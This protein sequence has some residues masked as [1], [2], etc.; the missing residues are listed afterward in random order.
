MPAAIP[1]LVSAAATGA[2]VGV[3]GTFA[4]T[5]GASLV[6]G[7][8]QQDRAESK[9][10]RAAQEAEEAARNAY[11]AS[12]Q[13]RLITVRSGVSTRKYVI[14]T[15]RTGGTLMYAN[16]TGE[17]QIAFDSIV[18]LASN[19]TELVGYYL[20]DEYVAAADFPGPKYGYSAG[21]HTA[22][23]FQQ[24]PFILS[25]TL[26]RDPIPGTVSAAAFGGEHGIVLTDFTV[27]GR[28]VTFSSGAY[29]D[30]E[31]G[32]SYKP[33]QKLYAIF[34]NGDPDQIASDWGSPYTSAEWTAEH[35][36]RGVTYL[37]TLMLWDEN[38]YA[39]GAPQ[40]GAVLSGGRVGEYRFIDPRT[41]GDTVFTRNPALVAY[42]WM[43]LP[44]GLG[45]MGIPDSWIDVQSIIN[46]ANICD[47]LMQVRTHNGQAYEWVK[48]Y[49]CNTVLDTANSPESNMQTILDAMAG[50]KVF[51]GGRYKIV[52]GA[53]RPATMVITDN[54]VIGDKPLGVVTAATTGAPPNIATGRFA[55]DQQNWIEAS[56]TPVRNQTYIDRD[57]FESPIDLNLVATTDSRR[58]RYLLGI[59]LETGRPAFTCTVSV[60]G[61]GEDV[62]LLDTVQLSINNRDEYRGR[63]FEVL[64]RT[65]NW[66]GTFQLTLS[67][68]RPQT[69]ELD[70]DTLTPVNPVVLPDL[71]Y[72]WNVAPL[73]G[74][75]VDFS[76][77]QLMPDGTGVSHITLSW[78]THSQA[79]VLQGGWVE[80]RYRQVGTANWSGIPEVEAASNGT[81]FSASLIDTA[82]YE[83]QGRVRNSL[84]AYSR[85]VSAY[86]VVDGVAVVTP[87]LR[88][89]ASSL[90]FSVSADGAIAPATITLTPI[91]GGP[92]TGPV[93][94]TLVSGNIQ[95]LT[96]AGDARIVAASDMIT[97]VATIEARATYGTT[98]LTDLVTLIKVYDGHPGDPGAPGGTG[99]AGA[100][101]LSVF[102]TNDPI[103]LPADYN[104]SVTSYTGANTT[105]VVFSGTVDDSS[106]WVYSRVLGPGVTTATLA[107]NVLTIG[108]VATSAPPK[109]YVEMVASHPT[110]PA[111]TRRV[112]IAKLKSGEPG[113]Q[114]NPGAAG[115]RGSV[116][117]ATPRSGTGWS[118]SIATNAIANAGA[119][120]PRHLDRVTIYSIDAN[121]S[122]MRSY[123]NGSWQPIA[124][125]IN[126]N[127]VVLGTLGAEHLAAKSITTDKLA[128]QASYGTIL[129][130]DPGIE[131]PSVWSVTPGIVE[132]ANLGQFGFF[133]RFFWQ[134]W[135]QSS[136]VGPVSPVQRNKKYRVSAR[137][138]RNA[139]SNATVYLFVH[140]RD[141]NGVLISNPAWPN[142][143]GTYHY[144]G[145]IN[146]SPSVDAWSEYTVVFGPGTG[147]E[148]PN[149]ATQMG[150][151]ALL[152]YNNAG[153]SAVHAMVIREMVEGELVV[154]GS[155]KARNV[156]LT[157]GAIKSSTYSGFA[158][159]PFGQRGF[160]LGPGG[161]LLGNAN[162]GTPGFFE[163]DEAGNV[164]APGM[165]II[166]GQMTINGI[167]VLGTFQV[168][169]RSIT[170]VS[171][172]RHAWSLSDM[173]TEP[174][175]YGAG[176]SGDS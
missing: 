131:D 7:A 150:V 92:L 167:N 22:Q 64:G 104:G 110:L 9:A 121:W 62:S 90:L 71:S 113:P 99:E 39:Q 50:R 149:N 152:S 145:L 100:D 30:I 137:A 66:D 3:L 173:P 127:M 138:S 129:N 26:D 109:T 37:R 157:D 10:K 112:T 88:I 78:W 46:S 134:A 84:G 135:S 67:E 160:F 56:P 70:P 23:Q 111:L 12:V 43:R 97:D 169:G 76:P 161:L 136:V 58:A 116:E 45:G 85:W 57:G 103:V 17:N 34:K 165:T 175:I 155:I 51:T 105:M 123:L 80:L 65:D 124:A 14:G 47:E 108:S 156:D 54:D 6:V 77:A 94:W 132:R 171:F 20:N 49:E 148:I 106:N 174:Y 25:F 119:G 133:G 24:T 128:V 172:S 55:D 52:A 33:P 101:A 73:E 21:I 143:G 63:T 154:D 13:D 166:N 59:A 68:I 95:A 176:D 75:S 60:G 122:E 151:G 96:V 69:W 38:I 2:G 40:V 107:G 74:F 98:T 15:V 146:G 139:G 81:Q 170:S 120:L 44:R 126:G 142:A 163:V 29:R 1:I 28:V 53:F 87:S 42:W 41:G 164:Y 141:A 82:A 86:E 118:D 140:F 114:G 79:Y 162:G 36:L 32:Y 48:R 91:F 130:P 19:V 159:P 4:L 18:A 35:R 8:Y 83:F 11:N 147:R 89:Q 153:H 125:F 168:R 93:T 61:L 27:S 31:I 72:L 144:Y 158:W 16:T 102:F 115:T 117:L 5:I